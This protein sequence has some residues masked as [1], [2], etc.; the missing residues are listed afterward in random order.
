MAYHAVAAQASALSFKNS[1]WMMALV[2]GC[3][4]HLPFLMRR[5]KPGEQELT[6]LQ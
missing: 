1:F 2:V 3:L 4:A 6:S 5:P